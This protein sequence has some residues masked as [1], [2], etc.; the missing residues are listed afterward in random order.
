MEEFAQMKKNRLLCVRN[1]TIKS[2]TFQI[3]GLTF[4]TLRS[5]AVTTIGD[6]CRFLNLC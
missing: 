6:G 4:T 2:S 3:I 1:I 5:L